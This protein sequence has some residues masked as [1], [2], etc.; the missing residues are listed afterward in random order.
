MT[1]K[2]GTVI[3]E[4]GDYY[5]IECRLGCT[6]LEWFGGALLSEGSVI[7]GELES[8]GMKSVIQVANGNE[9]KVWVEDFLLDEAEAL[10]K[11]RELSGR[12]E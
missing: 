2:T 8:F 6:I 3:K 7:K 9:T 12:T 1:M 5:V 4:L 10:E 11:T